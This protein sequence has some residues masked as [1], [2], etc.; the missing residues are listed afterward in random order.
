MKKMR[1]RLLSGIMAL[2]F[3]ISSGI[4]VLAKEVVMS[5]K[6]TYTGTA[7]T[8]KRFENMTV[9]Q[10]NQFI[11]SIAKSSNQQQMKPNGIT[12]VSP[13]IHFHDLR[14]AWLAAAMIAKKKGYPCSAELIK[15][16]VNRKDYKE[17]A[18]SSGLFRK[19][20]EKQHHTIIM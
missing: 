5:E 15:C 17:T 20:S 4:P 16:S 8:Q 12:P 2:P 11:D 9:E 13:I 6:G 3:V 14:D 10:L 19:K 7:A 1:K 18:S